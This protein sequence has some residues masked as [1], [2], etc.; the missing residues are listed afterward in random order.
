VP[1]CTVWEPAQGMVE[2]TDASSG[3]LVGTETIGPNQLAYIPVTPGT[4]DVTAQVAVGDGVLEAVTCTED[5][6]YESVRTPHRVGPGPVTAT[7]GKQ[8]D[9]IVTR[10]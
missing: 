4:Y 2:V 9:V 6:E 7:E 8:T 1:A 3:R 10:G 5:Y